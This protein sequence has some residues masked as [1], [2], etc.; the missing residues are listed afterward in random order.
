MELAKICDAFIA[1]EEQENL[2][3]L[4]IAGV[5]IWHGLRYRVYGHVLRALGM[6]GR[7]QMNWRDRGAK[8]V[9]KAAWEGRQKLPARTMWKDL[10]AADALVLPHPRYERFDQGWACPFSWPL[11]R[12]TSY[13]VVHLE[14]PLRGVH[15]AETASDD[16]VYPELVAA[17][18]GARILR[19]FWNLRPRRDELLEL[20]RILG[21][22]EAN[23]GSK[24]DEKVMWIDAVRFVIK[25]RAFT[26]M[27]EKLL[28][29]VRP[30]VI[31]E[32]V[33][34]A[35]LPLLLNQLARQ[36]GIPVVE[37]Q[38]GV[39]GPV[40]LAYRAAPGRQAPG[41]PDYFASFGDWWTRRTPGF[42]VAQG[43]CRDIGWSSLEQRIKKSIRPKTHGA[44]RLL[45]LSQA[46]IGRELTRW[47]VQVASDCPANWCIRLK[48][49]PGE[50]DGWRARY[51][52]LADAESRCLLEVAPPEAKLDEELVA[53]AMQVGVYSTALYEGIAFGCPTL[54]AGLPGAEQLGPLV[55]EGV[56]LWCHNAND[57]SAALKAPPRVAPSLRRKLFASDPEANF[58]AFLVELLHPSVASPA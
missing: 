14:E 54:V 31:L 49:H 6:H 9:L 38:H 24:I 5:P 22:F 10:H 16:V 36:R 12:D 46:S 35:D 57:I 40:H 48:L 13:S 43:R 53:A 2:W 7:R 32:V 50:Q 18:N 39:I 47:A 56:A 26:P 37:L 11:L 8:E 52:W 25:H 17:W 21:T 23:L 42:V 3:Q 19:R 51:P 55:E 44:H 29:K 34:Y 27:L 58:A 33:H 41:F 1:L 15:Y 20:R 28:D 45:F 4:Q 30:R